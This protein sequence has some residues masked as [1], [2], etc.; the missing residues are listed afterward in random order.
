MKIGLLCQQ[1]FLILSNIYNKLQIRKLTMMR[2]VY[3]INNLLCKLFY[4]HLY[5]QSTKTPLDIAL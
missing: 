5:Q 1:A 4:Y 2:F 3:T